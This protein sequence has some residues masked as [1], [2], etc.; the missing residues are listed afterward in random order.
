MEKQ[1]VGNRE[2]FGGYKYNNDDNNNN[3]NNNNN[4]N[5]NNNNKGHWGRTG[6]S[7]SLPQE[8]GRRRRPESGVAP[9]AS[10]HNL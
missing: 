8:D 1:E 6:W 7:V 10:A 5:N 2:T 4:S 3:N 9:L